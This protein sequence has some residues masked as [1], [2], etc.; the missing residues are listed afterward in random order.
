MSTSSDSVVPTLDQARPPMEVPR[1]GVFA[2]GAAAIAA[3]T[4]ASV[5]G[6]SP[7]HA[8]GPADRYERTDA[9]GASDFASAQTSANLD[10]LGAVDPTGN[11][12]LVRNPGDT[13]WEAVSLGDDGGK[14]L[15]QRVAQEVNIWDHLT[16]DPAT[17]PAAFND[18][19]D[20]AMVRVAAM[21]TGATIRIPAGLYKMNRRATIPL[22]PRLTVVCDGGYATTFEATAG[23]YT[24]GAMFGTLDNGVEHRDLTWHGGV[25]NGANIA[26][27]GIRLPRM[28]HGTFQDLKIVRTN[29][30]ALKINGYCNTIYNPNIYLNNG[31]GIDFSGIGLF[32]GLGN[33]NTNIFGGIIYANG[34]IGMRLANGWSM[35]VFGTGV[36]VNK[37]AGIIAYDVDGL[38]LR[39]CYFER[40]GQDGYVLDGDPEDLL[41][42]ADIHL[43]CDAPD[44][45]YPDPMKATRGVIIDGCAFTPYG[46]YDVPTPGLGQDCLVFGTSLDNVRFANVT[47]RG[48]ASNLKAA[49]GTYNNF[50]RAR[51]TG[52]VMESNDRSDVKLFGTGNPNFSFNTAHN[53]SDRS[54]RTRQNL[55]STNFLGAWSA[56]GGST[57][58]IAR[59]DGD[60]AHGFDAWNLTGNRR[61]E[62]TFSLPS[63]LRA[64]DLLWF[65][66][67][68]QTTGADTGL[69][70]Y[71]DSATDH[72]GS[73]T[74]PVTPAGEWRFR[75]CLFKVPASATSLT[76]KLERIGT[77]SAP[78]AISLPIVTEVGTS[79][80]DAIAVTRP[81]TYRSSAA[82]APT[83]GAWARGTRVL[84][85]VPAV[86][87]PKARICTVSGSPGTWVSEGDL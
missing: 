19:W 43:Y 6:A 67:H 2:V 24:D 11:S 12:V 32:G 71:A 83:A 79:T 52:L 27:Y 49:I 81:T 82:A 15:R 54:S 42:K 78:V 72:D 4:A 68:Y 76:V 40:N 37:V 75:S 30:W 8:A 10:A 57:G 20:A 36:E 59:R 60:G 58:T 1:R 50:A 65:G 77:G 41:I 13:A 61:W 87:S 17:N 23:T 29:A 31:G 14:R 35:N 9:S 34:G 5:A 53:I 69:L 63:Y 74:S 33:S 44:L 3:I 62:H 26:D 51:C 7:A 56:A 48:E 73:I 84:P 28:V 55:V 80:H 70:L 22:N 64:G 16:D 38:N 25:I 18:A 47:V 21:T 45:F 66:V 39:A 86:G 85:L 46:S